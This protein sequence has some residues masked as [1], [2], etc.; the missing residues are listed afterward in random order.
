MLR[1]LAV[2][3][4]FSDDAT[5]LLSSIA[6]ADGIKLTA[7]NLY[8]GGCSLEQH[9]GFLHDGSSPYIY[10][11]DG[12]LTEKKASLPETLADGKWDVVTVQQASHFSG[13]P[14]T[15][16][17]YA[18]ELVKVVREAQ[19]DARILFHQT[20]AYES[21]SDHPGFLHYQNSQKTM[22]EAILSCSYSISSA[23]GL[24]QI[25]NGEVIQA[26][27]AEKPFDYTN[28]GI[29]LN[30]DGFHL[31]LIYGRYAAAL[32]YYAQITGQDVRNN[33]FL[34]EGADPALI[35]LIRDTVY[36]V[37]HI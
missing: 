9:I 15:Y 26:L 34:P 27:R 24:E 30:R 33:R 16:S 1:I 28:G 12:V 21:D 31:N 18:G 3:N 8:V 7:V 22:Y 13:I 20:W 36:N 11:V 32:S 10:E 6:E 25:R 14:E 4:S 19:P 5:A 37:Y 23:L 35:S 17:P 2:G 29:S